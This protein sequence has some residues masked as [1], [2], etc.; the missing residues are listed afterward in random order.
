MSYVYLS[1]LAQMGQDVAAEIK[2]LLAQAAILD[3]NA[4]N[5]QTTANAQRNVPNM[6]QTVANLDQQAAVFRS[7][8]AERRNKA[9]EMQSSSTAAGVSGKD[10][11]DFTAR[12][13]AALAPAAASIVASTGRRPRVPGA[14]P[15]TPGVLDSLFGAA[16][17]PDT[18]PTGLS[19]LAWLGIGVGAVVVVVGAIKV[20]KPAPQPAPAPQ[21]VRA[22]KKRRN[23]VVCGEC[24]CSPCDCAADNG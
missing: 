21:G 8:A 7:Q 22:N 19:P 15:E 10:A 1:D 13:A 20:L 3:Q 24:G 17:P 11:M 4:S 16:P 18:K 2:Q 6:A 9:A 5:L 23:S 12:L 14:A